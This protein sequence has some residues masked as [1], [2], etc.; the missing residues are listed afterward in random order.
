MKFKKYLSLSAACVIIASVASAVGS[1]AEKHTLSEHNK[2][3]IESDTVKFEPLPE[4]KFVSDTITITSENI[5]KGTMAAG[6]FLPS[7]NAVHF[8][9]FVPGDTADNRIVAF[10]ELN[11]DLRSVTL[12]H[13]TEHAR[14]VLL[15]QNTEKRNPY[16]RAK[17]A[18]MNEIQAPASEVLQAIE[19]SVYKSKP[20]PNRTILKQ[21]VNKVFDKA[22]PFSFGLSYINYTNP[23]IA[24]EFL[25]YGINKFINDFNNGVYRWTLRKRLDNKKSPK[26]ETP[27]NQ[28]DPLLLVGYAPEYNK[29]G[30][31]FTYT[32]K[33]GQKIDIWNSATPK[34]RQKV[35]ER[36]DSAIT[37]LYRPDELAQIALNKKL[38]D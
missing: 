12:R 24:D 23:Q 35:L 8:N 28:A 15:T 5:D 36:L 11:N 1:T 6:V 16:V 14:K 33:T 9:Y 19:D 17:I 18:A 34:M 7:E 26:Y 2:E 29:W 3:K 22:A 30:P 27:H 32:T 31:M 38:H 4:L 10:C 37:S 21:A 13:E 20:V 25:N